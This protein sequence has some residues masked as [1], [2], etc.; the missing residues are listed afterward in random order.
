MAVSSPPGN[1]LFSLLCAGCA[2]TACLREP[3]FLNARGGQKVP[4]KCIFFSGPVAWA[5][6]PGAGSSSLPEPPFSNTRFPQTAPPQRWC[7]ASSAR[8]RF[9]HRACQRTLPIFGKATSLKNARGPQKVLAREREG[10]WCCS[11]LGSGL[12]SVASPGARRLAPAQCVDA[13]PSLLPVRGSGA[14]DQQRD[15]SASPAVAL[16]PGAL[17]PARAALTATTTSSTVPRPSPLRSAAAQVASGASPRTMLTPRAGSS[18]LT[19]LSRSQSPVQMGAPRASSTETSFESELT[20]T[21][22]RR[23]S[24]VSSA[25]P[26]WRGRSPMRTDFA[27]ASLPPLPPTCT[28]T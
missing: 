3:A 19:L 23:P 8:S 13:V 22:S 16:P 6:L 20:V 28:D 14:A 1:R 2:P 21:M 4:R 26:R 27:P 7:G 9:T 11:D 24:L 18:T 5:L 10:L 25:T 17:H 12:W 15:A